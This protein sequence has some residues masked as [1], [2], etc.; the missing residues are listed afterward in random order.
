[1]RHLFIVSNLINSLSEIDN[2]TP[3]PYPIPGKPPSKDIPEY[4]I[5]INNIMVFHFNEASNV[6]WKTLMS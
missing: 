4:P 5:N 3:P 2:P 6:F 1:M